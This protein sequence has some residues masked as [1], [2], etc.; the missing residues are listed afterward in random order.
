MTDRR[1]DGWTDGRTDGR[2][3][4]GDCNIP[5]AFLK[6]RVDKYN[7]FLLLYFDTLCFLLCVTWAHFRFSMPIVFL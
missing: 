1:M 5:D 6:K 7:N 4:R 3:D 2:T